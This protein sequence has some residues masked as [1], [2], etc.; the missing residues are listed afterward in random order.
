MSRQVGAS[1]GW[2]YKQAG[3]RCG[4]AS[5]ERL[6][7]LLAAGLLQPRQAVWTEDNHRLLF[8][9]A[10]TAAA[11]TTSDCAEPPSSREASA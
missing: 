8:V 4:P 6:K 7:E 5:A 2:F 1:Q 10:A 3:A 11:A 9:H